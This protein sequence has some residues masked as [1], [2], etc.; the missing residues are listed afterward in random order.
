[1]VALWESSLIF[2]GRSIAQSDTPRADIP[3]APN[4]RRTEWLEGLLHAHGHLKENSAANVIAV[5]KEAG[6]ADAA[7]VGR[8]KRLV[9]SVRYYKAVK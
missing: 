1:L 2:Q 9:G 3:K 8:W 5:M 6:F 4:T 7:K